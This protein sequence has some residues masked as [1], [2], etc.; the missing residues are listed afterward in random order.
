MKIIK[1]KFR[2]CIKLSKFN[3]VYTDLN[4]GKLNISAEF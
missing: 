4:L 2:N 1:I 3:A